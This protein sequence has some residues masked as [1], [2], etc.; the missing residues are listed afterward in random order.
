MFPTL[1]G[2][3]TTN[4]HSTWFHWFGGIAFLP[5]SVKVK[6]LWFAPKVTTLL[7]IRLKLV[8]IFHILCKT[9]KTIYIFIT[10]NWKNRIL[11]SLS[12]VMEKIIGQLQKYDKWDL[13][14]RK[15]LNN[16]SLTT[17][18]AYDVPKQLGLFGFT[19]WQL[20]IS[21]DCTKI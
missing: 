1:V 10:K 15:T 17:K 2:I 4:N 20:K 19:C 14:P 7:K 6:N 21:R 9:W 5:F 8:V 13:D 16:I 11:I 12:W 3:A 18:E